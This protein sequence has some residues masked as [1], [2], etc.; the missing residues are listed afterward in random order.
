MTKQK[1]GRAGPPKKS[2]QVATGKSNNLSQVNLQDDEGEVKVENG[3]VSVFHF[4]SE[5]P[6]HLYVGVAGYGEGY[7]CIEIYTE[8]CEVSIELSRKNLKKLQYLIQERL[9]GERCHFTEDDTL[10][11]HL[12]SGRIQEIPVDELRVI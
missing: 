5:K 8:E 2:G 11:R 12:E 1:K 7:D 3:S 9:K 4:L 6:L 10:I